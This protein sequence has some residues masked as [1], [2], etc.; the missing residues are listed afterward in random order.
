M[1]KRNLLSVITLMTLCGFNIPMSEAAPII[2]QKDT[3]INVSVIADDIENTQTD[4]INRVTFR[5]KLKKSPEAQINSFFK[6]YDK[7]STQN[8]TEKLKNLYSDSYIN[9]DGFN[10]EIVFKMMD[11]AADAYKNVKYTT[12]IQNISVTG[13]TAIV[14]IHETAIGETTKPIE[15]LN[16]TGNIKSDIYYIDYLRKEGIDW[17][18]TNSI[19]LSEKVELTYGEAKNSTFEIN[20]PECITAGTDYEVSVNAK[21]PSESFVVASIVN[22]P[23][24][25]PQVQKKDVFHAVKNDSIARIIKSNTDGNNEYATVSLAITRAQVE[26]SSV[27]INMTGM[28]FIMQRINVL[29]ENKNI[30]TE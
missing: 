10:K 24:T 16:G 2:P 28:A 17:K 18:I 15:K 7:Y 22:E 26:P 19:I 6:K 29:S 14:K 5:D 23:I 8:N 12:N 9:N 4:I 27:I 20:T 21:L 30:K 1:N 3:D 13:N 11:T 25:Y